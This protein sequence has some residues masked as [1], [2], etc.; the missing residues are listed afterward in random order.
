M[1]TD[2]IDNNDPLKNNED[3]ITNRLT[4]KYLNAEPNAFRYEPQ[5]SENYDDEIGR[6]IGRTDI[7]VISG[8]YFR[9]VQAYFIIECKRIDGKPDLNKKYISEGVSRFFTPVLNPKYSSYYKQNIMFGYVVQ[10][11][12]I[13]KNA[14][15]IKDLQSQ[16]LGNVTTGKFLL[17][18][19]DAADYYVYSCL[20]QSGGQNIELRHLFCDFS[21]AV[22]NE[23][24]S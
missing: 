9:D 14:E 12:D 23:T 19:H 10:A 17:L 6:Y 21:M 22:K 5:A 3:A 24:A 4:A 1:K 13:P 8:D 15:K 11:I 20:Y 7:K 2:C 18:C 16:I